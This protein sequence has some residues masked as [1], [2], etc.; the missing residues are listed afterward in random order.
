MLDSAARRDLSRAL[1]LLSLSSDL[2]D[3]I[4]WAIS[5]YKATEPGSRDTTVANTLA[6]IEDLQKEGRR[7]ERAV[8]R[9]ADP[10]SGIDYT[11]HQCLQPLARGVL[12]GLPGAGE[13]LAAVAAS[14]AAELRAH[15][16]VEAETE[17]LR[18]FCGCLREI[19]NHAI[20]GSSPRPIDELWHDCR[21]F[22]LTVFAIAGID[23]RT[24]AA[25]PDRLQ[26]YLGTD[27]SVD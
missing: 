25:H 2:E 21:R 15:P 11:T 23:E 12:D 17:A 19:F 9:G 1:G 8:A 27:V 14:R 10:R 16:R 7:Y 18:F 22:A 4:A 13:A 5:C 6:A 20:A 24:F 26:E 3:G